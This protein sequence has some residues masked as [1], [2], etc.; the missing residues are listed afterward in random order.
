MT[1]RLSWEVDGADWPNRKNS[2]FVDAGGIRWHAQRW[3][4]AGAEAPTV[5]ML[6]GTGASTHSWRALGPLLAR[7]FNV[8][9]MDLPGHGFSSAPPMSAMGISGMS[10]SV[11]ALV[12]ALDV[13]PALL[14]GHSAGAAIAVQM[15][16]DGWT[17]PQAIIGLNAAL[18]PFEGIQGKLFSPMAKLLAATDWAPRLFSWRAAD[19]HVLRRLLEGTGSK[20]DSEGIRLYGKLIHNPHHASAALAMMANWDLNALSSRMAHL[21]PPLRLAMGGNDRAVPREH[22]PRIL[23]S[24]PSAAMTEF[25]ALGHLAHEEA[26]TEI[27][28]WI[29]L[30]A[31]TLC[32]L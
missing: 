30:Q 27:G 13:R 17:A 20:L 25:P 14:V 12:K 6:H 24:L 7:H 28:D 15:S 29:V 26:P 5:V 21:M 32:I 16:L 4:S 23:A 2:C 10:R 1:Q 31:E 19:P 22:G 18:V 3:F 11:G 9:A 8:V